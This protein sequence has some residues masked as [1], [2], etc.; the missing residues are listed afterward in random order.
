[1]WSYRLNKIKS[2]NLDKSITNS[3]SLAEEQ[4]DQTLINAPLGQHY[5]SFFSKIGNWYSLIE[6]FAASVVLAL[7]LVLAEDQGWSKFNVY[8]FLK[9][10]LFID[11]VLFTL[12]AIHDHF[13]N[14]F[15]QMSLA[16][17][18]I[19]SFILLQVIVVLTT[20]ALN[21]FLLLGEHLNLQHLNLNLLFKNTLLHLSYGVLLGAF[22]FRYLYVREQWIRQQH[23]ELQAKIDA[24]QAR[25]HPHFLFNSLNNVVSLISTQPEKAENLLLNLSRLFRA[26]LQ[27]FKLINLLDEIELSKKYLEIEQNRLGERLNI[28]WKFVQIEKFSQ[29]KIPLLTLQPL[30][31]N[32][33]FHGVEKI[34]AKSTIGILIEIFQ[35]NVN[36]VI[37]N[38]YVPANNYIRQHH[39]IAIKNVKAR[40]EAYYGESVIFR[41]YES[42]GIYTTVIQYQYQ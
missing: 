16:R 5:A 19:I 39:G 6:L 10:L 20:I 35:N 3:T 1:M 37:T 42:G 14:V 9:Y 26:S 29:V 15:L 33:I 8:Q 34:L 28:E 38:P 17:A 40:L 27:E 2:S 24:L 4:V 25:I 11:W 31:E 13:E 12:I 32:S 23:S 21:F 22:S 41:T 36:I 18:L 30:L 7:I